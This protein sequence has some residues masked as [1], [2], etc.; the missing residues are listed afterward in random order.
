MKASGRLDMR[1]TTV[2][3]FLGFLDYNSDNHESYF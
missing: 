3:L 2:C 1:G